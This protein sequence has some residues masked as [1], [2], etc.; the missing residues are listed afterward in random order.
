MTHLVLSAERGAGTRPKE[1]RPWPSGLRRQPRG[2]CLPG[3]R[4]KPRGKIGGPFKPVTQLPRGFGDSCGSV[5]GKGGSPV[6]DGSQSR[7]IPEL[8]GTPACSP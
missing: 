4:P 2:A 3:R 6:P 1:L 7:D 5:R 8:S